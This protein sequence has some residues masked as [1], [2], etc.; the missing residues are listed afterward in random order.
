[1]TP[2]RHHIA[3]VLSLTMNTHRCAH[4]TLAL[5]C[6][7]GGVSQ[8]SQSSLA[9]VPIRIVAQDWSHDPKQ[10]SHRMCAVANHEHT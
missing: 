3:C 10:T 1:M 6:S 9:H 8:L 4:Q 5:A 2:S 7:E